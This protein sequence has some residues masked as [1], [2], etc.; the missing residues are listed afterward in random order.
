MSHNLELNNRDS[1]IFKIEL[2]H[3]NSIK[4]RHLPYNLLSLTKSSGDS[5]DNKGDNDRRNL[6]GKTRENEPVHKKRSDRNR[7]KTRERP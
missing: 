1:F 7:A 4:E 5:R 6:L 3:K 2:N